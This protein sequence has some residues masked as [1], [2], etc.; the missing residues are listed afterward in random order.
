MKW[1]GRLFGGDL[2]VD[3]DMSPQRHSA[4]AH[5][6]GHEDVAGSLSLPGAVSGSRPPGHLIS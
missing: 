3:D 4:G 6:K 2:A 1:V 5:G